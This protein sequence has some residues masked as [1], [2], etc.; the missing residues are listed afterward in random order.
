MFTENK[1]WWQFVACLDEKEL[2][3]EPEVLVTRGSQME[4]RA[5]NQEQVK[6]V[7]QTYKNHVGKAKAS[8][9]CKDWYPGSV[10]YTW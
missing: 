5:S 6:Q 9:S 3:K 2:F 4:R 1:F 8:S 7:A 10:F